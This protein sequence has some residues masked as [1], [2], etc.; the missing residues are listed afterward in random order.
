MRTAG[1]YLFKGDHW[2][3]IA[4]DDVEQLMAS[5]RQMVLA[6]RQSIE[7]LRARTRATGI[8]IEQSRFLLER[9]RP[10]YP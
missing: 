6:S 2:E 10:R 3:D 4:R 1:D 7:A 5:G 8:L 9:T